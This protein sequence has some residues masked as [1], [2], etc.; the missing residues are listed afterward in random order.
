MNKK[1]SITVIIGNMFSGKTSLLI[2]KFNQNKNY[3]KCLAF[4]PTLDKRY[5][6]TKIISH[7][8]KAIPAI[9][10]STILEIE[11]YKNEADNIYIDEVH[12]FKGQ[13]INQ[14]LNE[15][16]NQDKEIVLAG[17]TWD[18][19]R[20]EPFLDV[21]YLVATAE[22]PI[23][24]FGKCDI[25]DCYERSTKQRWK[26]GWLPKKPEDFVGGAE[27]YGSYC[28]FHYVSVPKN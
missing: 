11:K 10:I 19:F 6:E 16:A 3:R 27:K 14:Y 25:K 4:K 20:D 5:S 24:L 7:D 28:R 1:G 23:R 17:L 12:F 2:D 8:K 15:L 18:C 13:N 22:F 9:P 21:A 26:L